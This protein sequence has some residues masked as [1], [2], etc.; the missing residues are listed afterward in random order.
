MK[1]KDALRYGAVLKTNN[2]DTPHGY[3]TIQLI[4]FN[5]CI[6]F[7]KMKNGEEV[8]FINLNRAAG[9]NLAP[10]SRRGSRH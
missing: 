8:E 10:R 1:A 5:N 9:F 4:S 6:F 2:F 7:H 3:Y